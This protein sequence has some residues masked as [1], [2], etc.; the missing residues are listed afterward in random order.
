[1]NEDQSQP[2][3]LRYQLANIFD[4]DHKHVDSGFFSS[5]A[6]GGG[7]HATGRYAS[8]VMWNW[9]YAVLITHQTAGVP[10]RV[11]AVHDYTKRDYVLQHGNHYSTEHIVMHI[12]VTLPSFT[13]VAEIAKLLLFEVMAAD[14]AP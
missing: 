3:Q 8:R 2:G 7:P 6:F 4:I 10:G 5:N 9:R 14:V 12:T 1:M 11:I 13:D